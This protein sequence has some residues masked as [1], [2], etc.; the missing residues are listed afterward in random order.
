[1][2]IRV[3]VLTNPVFDFFHQPLGRQP[4]QT[5]ARRLLFVARHR[6]SDVRKF[7]TVLARISADVPRSVEARI[8]Q[9]NES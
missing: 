8:F 6:K 7:A 9:Q 2:M 1:V 4:G 3:R 5:T